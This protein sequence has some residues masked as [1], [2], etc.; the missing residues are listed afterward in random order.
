MSM[1]P[2]ERPIPNPL[3]RAAFIVSLLGIPFFGLITG[4]VAVLLAATA[5]SR[6]VSNPLLRGRGTAMAAIVIG[7]GAMILWTAILGLTFPHRD[8]P[9][10]R[11][12]ERL[13]FPAGNFL[14]GAREPIRKALENNVFFHVT[15]KRWPAFLTIESIS[16]SGVILGKQGKNYLILTNRHVVDPCFATSAYLYP[17]TSSSITAH[18]CDGT[19]G[20]A[21]VRWTGPGNADL[22]LVTVGRGSES[23]PIPQL[24]APHKTA[25]GDKVFTVGNPHDLTWSYHEGVISAIREATVGRD[26][27]RIYQTQTP[28]NEGNSGGG[29]YS[30]DGTL[31]GIVTW[32]RDKS[33]SE[34]IGFAIAYT[35]FLE[36]L[37]V[38]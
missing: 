10:L 3:A 12:S 21:H 31:L 37:E 14:D 17:V 4:P 25:I 26:R 33:Q 24:N 16:G 7:L 36:L 13:T 19:R 30:E 18:F 35:S 9:V 22:A 32:T 8:V 1:I 11:Q 34:G 20:P 2:E 28:I 29:L 27:L 6:M 38:E 15:R 23:I 5:L